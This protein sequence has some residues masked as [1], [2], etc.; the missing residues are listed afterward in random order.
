MAFRAALLCLALP[1]YGAVHE[2]LAAVPSGWKETSVDVPDSTTVR[3]NVA[4]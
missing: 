1:V 2:S 4:L 3:L